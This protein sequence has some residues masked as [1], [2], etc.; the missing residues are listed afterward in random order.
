MRFGHAIQC[1]DAT[2]TDIPV[3]QYTLEASVHQ[4]LSQSLNGLTATIKCSRRLVVRPTGTFGSL[5]D[6]FIQS[7]EPVSGTP[8]TVLD[9]TCTPPKILRKG[10]LGRQVERYLARAGA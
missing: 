5:V 10:P 4:P 3:L 6:L 9:L 7:S 2:G 1:F 8:S